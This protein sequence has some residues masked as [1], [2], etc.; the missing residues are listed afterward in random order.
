VL[1]GRPFWHGLNQPDGFG[2]TTAADVADNN[3]ITQTAVFFDDETQN[4]PAFDAVL[5]C[6][7][8][9]FQVRSEELGL[10]SEPGTATGATK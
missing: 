3:D 9:I 10:P 4:D 8:R 5:F 1:A 6:Q 2:T 7:R